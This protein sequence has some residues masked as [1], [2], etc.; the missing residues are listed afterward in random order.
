M[1]ASLRPFPSLVG[2]NSVKTPVE[3]EADQSVPQDPLETPSYDAFEKSSGP[4][5]LIPNPATYPAE[6][7]LEA[8]DPMQT[9]W[10]FGRRENLYNK[11]IVKAVEENWRD[12]DF[13]L[14]PL[15]FKALV[16]AESA[17]DKDAVSATGAVGLVQITGGTARAYGVKTDP[18]PDERRFPDV[19]LPAGVRILVDKHALIV[20]PPK[21]RDY[22][23]PVAE[24]YETVGPPD[25]EQTKML[26]L[27]GYNGGAS[28]VLRAMNYAIADGQDPRD[29]SNLV[30]ADKDMKDTPLYKAI[31]DTFGDKF[32]G[33]KYHEMAAYPVRIT[34]FE[35]REYKPLRDRK[36]MVDAGHGG[37]DPGARGP[38]GSREGDVNLAVSLK[39]RDKLE[40]LG[41]DVRMTR[42]TDTNVGKVGIPQR[43]EL[44]AR[45][46]LANEWPAEV[47]VSVHSNSAANPA[48]HGT[49]TYHSRQS[50]LASRQLAAAVNTEMVAATGFRNRGVKAANFYVIKNTTMPGV[51]VETGFI[52]NAVEEA[53]LVD[54]EMQD[55]M[56]EAVS[57][58]VETVFTRTG[59]SEVANP[60]RV[61]P[62]PIELP[63]ADQEQFITL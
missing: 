51:L 16:A 24:Y 10:G 25:A 37:T 55:K 42:E 54:P 63:P 49:E 36:I 15:T 6:S 46:D 13:P 20:A 8:R 18:P 39:L 21:D 19:A 9:T 31:E 14:S 23:A 44:K 17:F 45:A 50:S 29:W 59:L 53:H 38:A 32:A 35:S 27:A 57:R 48:A 5:P 7:K 28:T 12:N 58:G 4:G 41:A 26:A 30:A 1:L 40:A 2:T 52:S 47:F 34:N 60:A 22:S 62:P 3:R 61:V 56:A 43:E 11:E 33:G